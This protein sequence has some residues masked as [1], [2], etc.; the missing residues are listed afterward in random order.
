MTKAFAFSCALDSGF[1]GNLSVYSTAADTQ[2][3][4]NVHDSISL[5]NYFL[6]QALSSAAA[7]RSRLLH[8]GKPFTRP[9]TYHAHALKTSA[10]LL[11]VSKHQAAL[12]ADAKKREEARRQR[13]LKAEAV[14]VQRAREQEK[15][16]ERRET[17][18]LGKLA[19]SEVQ[20]RLGSKNGLGG[21]N[22]T[23]INKNAISKKKPVKTSAKKSFKDKK[24]GFGGKEKKMAKRNSKESAADDSGFSVRKNKAPFKGMKSAKKGGMK[25]G[26]KKGG[27]KKR[28]F[29][30]K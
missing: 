24:Y 15:I 7:A 3:T 8:A 16:E 30:R 17:M 25:S 20:T 1:L 22:N 27:M 10:H 6:Q 26:P 12:D 13:K 29:N 19:E 14:Q 5:E 21:K 23:H 4:T 18:A 9:P 11:R 28:S 2:A